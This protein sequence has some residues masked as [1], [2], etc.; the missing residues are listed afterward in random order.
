MQTDAQQNAT[1][2]EAVARKHE[3]RNPPVG[4]ILLTAVAIVL[5][6]AGCEAIIWFTMGKFAEKRP[7]DKTVEARGIVIAPNLEIL[8]RFPA[9]HLQIN[10]HDDLMALRAREDAELNGYG[11]VDHSNGIVRIPIARAMDLI[12]ARGLPTRSWGIEH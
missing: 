7:L 12:L 9:P 2:L 1:V 11:W 10:S 4:Y 8:Q 3:S 5:M 6:M